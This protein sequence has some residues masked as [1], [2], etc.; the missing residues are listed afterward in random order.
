MLI[1][2]D[3]ESIFVERNAIYLGANTPHHFNN[4]EEFCCIEEFQCLIKRPEILS[5][6]MPKPRPSVFALA[7]VY[8]GQNSNK[9]EF[10]FDEYLKCIPKE[11]Q[12]DVDFNFV[13]NNI[14]N[15][16]INTNNPI[17]SIKFEKVPTSCHKEGKFAY[18][19]YFSGRYILGLIALIRSIRR[20]S[21]KEIIVLCNEDEFVEPL[22]SEENISII[23]IEQIENPNSNGQSRFKDTYNKLKIFDFTDYDKLIYIDSDCIVLKNI[24][25]LFSL[26]TSI[27]ASPDWG[28][29][30]SK[31]FNSGVIVFTPSEDLRS[32][33]KAGLTS[34]VT[35][36]DGGDQGFLNEV[37]KD[38]IS[39][40]S[41]EFN[42][43]KRSYDKRS[44]VFD[45]QN[46]SIL[47]YVGI[48]P[49]DVLDFDP[50]YEEL[51]SLWLE[52]LNKQDLILLYKF[53]KTFASRRINKLNE[54]ISKKNT[55]IKQLSSVQL[56]EKKKHKKESIFSIKKAI[57]TIKAHLS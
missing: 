33:I 25:R 8:A 44:W 10:D 9:I 50:T 43:L 57:S 51:N 53:S 4:F 56:N 28:L 16:K 55:Q 26:E 46:I 54:T 39:Y 31:G 11:S 52:M 40:L 19:T 21:D 38:T 12:R 27:S 41:P 13:K 42:Y 1:R 5:W 30:Y 6:L 49:W 32:K 20:F 22:H 45:I 18:I 17:W 7:M 23:R 35:S 3:N 34:N 48:K 29:K 15:V 2:C 47:H 14:P 24:D 37:L 36:S